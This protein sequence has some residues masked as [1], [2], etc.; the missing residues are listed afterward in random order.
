M[1]RE[2]PRVIEKSNWTGRGL[3][4]PRSLFA[5]VHRREESIRA[6]L[7]L[8]KLIS[9][10]VREAKQAIKEANRILDRDFTHIELH[11]G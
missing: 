2:G 5:G 11:E 4:L 3:A 6:T 8:P 1:S 7:P 9:G 10:E